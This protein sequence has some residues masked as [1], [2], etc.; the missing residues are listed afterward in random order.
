MSNVAAVGDLERLKAFFPPAKD[1]TYDEDDLIDPLWYACSGGHKDVAEFLI[2]QG[3]K[4]DQIHN[5]DMT[6]IQI[7]EENGH[8]ELADWLESQE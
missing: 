1:A 7:A 2:R 8:Q 3:A 4:V 6:P 5:E